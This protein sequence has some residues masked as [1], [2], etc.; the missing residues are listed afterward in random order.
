MPPWYDYRSSIT[1][2]I[3]QDGVTSIG[4]NAFYECSNLANVT[5]PDSVTSIGRRAFDNCSSLTDVYYYGTEEQW[6]AISIGIFNDPL[7]NATIHFIAIGGDSNNDGKID[8]K[9]A[10]LL[11][12]Y[13]AEWTVTINK[14][15]ADCNGDGKVDIKDAV[16]LAQ[17]IAEWDVELVCG[18]S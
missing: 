11:A 13:L 1:K 15:A 4:D 5:I 2:V 7:L 8:I 17:Y 12:Q 3:I 10:V 6:N 18:K 14:T 9:D 16:L